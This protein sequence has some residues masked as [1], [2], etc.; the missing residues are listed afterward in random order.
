LD[1][2][3]TFYWAN[4]ASFAI[5][6]LIFVLFVVPLSRLKITGDPMLCVSSTSPDI[7]DLN[8][9]IANTMKTK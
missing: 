5:H 9:V 8:K 7:I 1:T 3:A 6:L 4:R 2:L